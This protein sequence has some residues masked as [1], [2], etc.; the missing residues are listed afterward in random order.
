[1]R[2]SERDQWL[3]AIFIKIAELIKRGTFEFVSS[4]N[5]IIGPLI[6]GK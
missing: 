2:E 6:D 4:S 5:V 1:M 3:K